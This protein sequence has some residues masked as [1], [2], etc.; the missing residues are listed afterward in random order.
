MCVGIPMEVVTVEG[1][2]AVCRAGE[3]TEQVDLSLVGEVAPGTFLL[4]FLGAAREV[5]SPARADEITRALNGLRAL[6]AGKG[7]G[8]AFADLEAQTPTLPPHL[9]AARKAGA[10]QG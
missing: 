9:E 1:L 3:A 6:M 5:L 10:T 8:D 2:S 7:L 4:V